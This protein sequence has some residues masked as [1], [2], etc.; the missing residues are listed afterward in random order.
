M[1]LGMVLLLLG[2]GIFVYRLRAYESFATS[3]ADS[4]D[5]NV[6]L[7]TPKADEVEKADAIDVDDAVT[8]T[9]NP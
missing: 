7:L 8:E 6:R 5:N 9:Y 4:L 2:A 1:I 3:V